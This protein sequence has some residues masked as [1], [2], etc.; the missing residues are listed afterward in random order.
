M[1]I[2]SGFLANMIRSKIPGLKIVMTIPEYIGQHNIIEASLQKQ[3]EEND[4]IFET[5]SEVYQRDGQQ[6]GRRICI[7]TQK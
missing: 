3:A 6:V 2:Y 5:V 1:E 4:Y 7:I